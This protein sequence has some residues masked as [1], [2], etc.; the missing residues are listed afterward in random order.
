[1]KW[2]IHLTRG[3]RPAFQYLHSV[4]ECVRGGVCTN[5]PDETGLVRTGRSVASFSFYDTHHPVADERSCT[6]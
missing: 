2:N 4:R 3:V 5:G 6:V 1:M